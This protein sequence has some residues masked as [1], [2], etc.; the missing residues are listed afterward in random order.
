MCLKAQGYLTPQPPLFQALAGLILSA[1]RRFMVSTT[2][3]LSFSTRRCSLSDEEVVLDIAMEES[4]TRS[5]AAGDLIVDTY[6]KCLGSVASLIRHWHQLTEL[7][8]EYEAT[9]TTRM[10]EEYGRIRT[11]G[12]E[13]RA[14]LPA[15][16]QSSLDETLRQDVSLRSVVTDILLRINQRAGHGM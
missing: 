3:Y 13:S 16:S 11:W 7:G 5:L 9:M 1:L 10:L 14:A 6:K 8:L 15:A 2:I 12:E 4:E